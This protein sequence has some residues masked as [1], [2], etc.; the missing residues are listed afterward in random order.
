[1]LMVMFYILR[2]GRP[3]AMLFYALATVSL[4]QKLT[5]LVT[6]V[7]Y[8]DDAPLF[9]LGGIKCLLWVPPLATFQLQVL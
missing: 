2:K 9:K 4:I 5:A 7:W 6:Q 1:M 8:A 3:L